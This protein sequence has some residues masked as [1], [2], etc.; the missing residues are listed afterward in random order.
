MCRDGRRE[1]S[2]RENFLGN[3][4]SA[5]SFIEADWRRLVQLEAQVR[6]ENIGVFAIILQVEYDC[7]LFNKV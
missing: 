7:A 5:E 4:L 6:K 3:I 2:V 1:Y